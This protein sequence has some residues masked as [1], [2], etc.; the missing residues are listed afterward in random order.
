MTVTLDV[1]PS[2]PL[3]KGQVLIEYEHPPM[4]SIHY[5][6]IAVDDT[7]EARQIFAGVKPT[8]RIRTATLTR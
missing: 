1:H 6:L 8:A 5:A 2:Q 4:R 3:P 7:M